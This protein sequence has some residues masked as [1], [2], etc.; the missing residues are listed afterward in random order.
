[1]NIN[2]NPLRNTAPAHCN[3]RLVNM[4]ISKFKNGSPLS[5]AVVK[6]LN[7][8]PDKQDEHLADAFDFIVTQTDKENTHKPKKIIRSAIASGQALKKACKTGKPTVTEKTFSIYGMDN[9][10]D[11]EIAE[12]LLGALKEKYNNTL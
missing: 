6:S 12:K 3:I 1:M 10:Y 8:D 4:R 7:D 9:N 2:I 5:H 11:K